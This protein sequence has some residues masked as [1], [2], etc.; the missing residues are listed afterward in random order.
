MSSALNSVRNFGS[1][2]LDNIPSNTPRQVVISFTAMF[3]VG[4]I[5]T[6]NPMGGLV[7]G[8]MSAIA[9]LLHAAVTPLFK[10]F[11]GNRRLNFGG[12]FV[13]GGVAIIGAGT[14]GILIGN[15]FALLNVGVN[16]LIYGI[17]LGFSACGTREMFDPNRTNWM[18]I[19]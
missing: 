7:A 4:T 1:S 18:Y 12:E 9:A 10:S 2:Y 5:A 6:A 13:R 19:V 3:V 16:A 8:G 11:L 15:P 14:I 17:R